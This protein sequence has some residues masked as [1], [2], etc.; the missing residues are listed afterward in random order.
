[1]LS[2]I[3][4]EKEENCTRYSKLPFM[5]KHAEEKTSSIKSFPSCTRI[6]ARKYGTGDK[7]FRV[8][9]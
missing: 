5:Q 3:Q 2:P 6:Y 7:S 9:T 1:M 4:I 8:F